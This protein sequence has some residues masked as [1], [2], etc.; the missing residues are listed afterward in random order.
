MQNPVI[1]I[2]LKRWRIYFIITT[3]N[4]NKKIKIDIG[5]IF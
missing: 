1:I 2:F 4:N 3:N 5:G